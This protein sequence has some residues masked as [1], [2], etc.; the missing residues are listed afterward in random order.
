MFCL[1]F[2]LFLNPLALLDYLAR[3]KLVYSP[4]AKKSFFLDATFCTGG[5]P[6]VIVFLPQL[7]VLLPAR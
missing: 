6:G 4:K 5:T 7:E 2:V 3:S 1:L